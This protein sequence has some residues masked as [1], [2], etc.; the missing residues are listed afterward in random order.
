MLPVHTKSFHRFLCK[1]TFTVIKMGDLNEALL[2][3]LECPYCRDYMLPP[4]TSCDNGHDACNVC[5]NLLGR[6]LI[7]YRPFLNIRNLP[8]ENLAKTS[9]FPCIKRAY[10][11]TETVPMDSVMEH[12][13]SC[14]YSNFTACPFAVMPTLSCD[15]KGPVTTVGQHIQTHHEHTILEVNYG[16]FLSPL[17]QLHHQTFHQQVIST[18]NELFLCFWERV[19]CDICLSIFYV[20]PNNKARYFKYKLSIIT[21]HGRTSFSTSRRVR[22][23]DERTERSRVSDYVIIPYSYLKKIPSFN[24]GNNIQ[25]IV[26]ILSGTNC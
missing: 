13:K 16:K 17:P 15:W 18:M 23:L 11:C 3:V 7:C 10:G 6:C 2:N 8:L 26:E 4:I 25:Y 9:M 19:D 20:G 21:T 5:K 14:P 12:Q 1:W 24:E 22:H